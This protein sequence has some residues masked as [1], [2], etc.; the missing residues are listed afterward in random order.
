MIVCLL[1]DVDDVVLETDGQE[2]APFVPFVRIV[3]DHSGDVLT[4]CKVHVATVP[5]GLVLVRDVHETR[6]LVQIERA[7]QLNKLVAFGEEDVVVAVA[8]ISGHLAN[9][10]DVVLVKN[11]DE[12]E[13]IVPSILTGAEQF[14]DVLIPCIVH[15]FV[16]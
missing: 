1:A 12:Y 11:G 8:K 7:P 3:A 4:T 10:D 2:C 6:L 13:P 9:A 15:G 14:V 5:E 16:G